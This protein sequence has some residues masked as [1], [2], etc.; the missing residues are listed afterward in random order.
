MQEIS[1]KQDLLLAMLL[2]QKGNKIETDLWPFLRTFWE[3]SFNGDLKQQ[4]EWRIF[5]KCLRKRC[6]AQPS[7]HALASCR[8]ST[9]KQDTVLILPLACETPAS[10]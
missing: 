2:D 7:F 1:R 4:Q 6:V 10:F 8:L 5:E 3:G 9:G